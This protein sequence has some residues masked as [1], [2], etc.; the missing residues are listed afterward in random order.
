MV[1]RVPADRIAAYVEPAR[2]GV[3]RNPMREADLDLM[4]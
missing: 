3:V 2:Q 4:S 1:R